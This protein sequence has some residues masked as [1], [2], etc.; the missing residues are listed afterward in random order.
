MSNS[1]NHQESY[2]RIIYQ[3]K[4]L[5][6]H[7]KPYRQSHKALPFHKKRKN[8]L[9]KIIIMAQSFGFFLQ[10][11]PRPR[12]VRLPRVVTM[13]RSFHAAGH[14]QNWERARG[15]VDTPN[16]TG[17]VCVVLGTVRF[18]SLYE[19]VVRVGAVNFWE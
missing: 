2:S 10:I 19:L 15:L 18:V 9:N 8:Y 16:V 12:R 13:A 6:S 11:N 7:F 14:R 1:V 4:Y 5:H 17:P 3:D